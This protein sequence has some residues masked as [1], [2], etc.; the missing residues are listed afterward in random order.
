[1]SEE[2]GVTKS[3]IMSQEELKAKRADSRRKKRGSNLEV[4][5]NEN[6]E[7]RLR[8]KSRS[9]HKLNFFC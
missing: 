7:M 8:F 1:M 9:D 2:I 6:G 3:Y 4:Y 5:I